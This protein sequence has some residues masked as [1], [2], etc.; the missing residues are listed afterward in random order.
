[1]SGVCRIAAWE[2]LARLDDGSLIAGLFLLSKGGLVAKSSNNEEKVSK[3]YLDFGRMMV[4]VFS[5]G[6][7][8]SALR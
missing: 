2:G 6:I 5:D 7:S 1:M 3:G 4:A 8:S